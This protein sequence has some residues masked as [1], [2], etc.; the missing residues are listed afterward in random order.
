MPC[1]A[2]ANCTTDSSC[3]H[4]RGAVLRPKGM[5]MNWYRPPSKRKQKY[6]RTAGCRGKDRKQLDRS[7]LPYQQP[8]CE[9]STAS[10]T[11]LYW[12]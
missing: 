3:V 10:S 7:S 12:K 5:W 6:L 1:S 4:T 9:A 2:S 11:Q 8:G